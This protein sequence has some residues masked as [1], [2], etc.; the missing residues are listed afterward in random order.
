MYVC[1]YVYMYLYWIVSVIYLDLSGGTLF[2]VFVDNQHSSSCGQKNTIHLQFSVKCSKY[3]NKHT[4]IYTNNTNIQSHT[5]KHIQTYIHNNP[6]FYKLHTNLT[7]KT[8]K[9]HYQMATLPRSIKTASARPLNGPFST[10]DSGTAGQ[11]GK[12]FCSRLGSGDTRGGL[13]NLTRPKTPKG[14]GFPTIPSVHI[15][16]YTFFGRGLALLG[17]SPQLGY[18]VNNH[19]WS[20]EDRVMGP[21]PNG[22]FMAYAWGWS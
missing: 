13:A 21:L 18:V 11:W 2:L 8:N 17:G 5:Y 16:I 20:P 7:Y 22:L 6:T 12:A 1:M 19:G 9:T 3:M 14:G 15:Q 4:D 10:K